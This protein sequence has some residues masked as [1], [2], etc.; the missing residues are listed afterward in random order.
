MSTHA[1]ADLDDASWQWAI[2]FAARGGPALAAYPDYARIVERFGRWYVASKAIARRHRM[3]IG[4]IASDAT[5]EVKW[6]RGGRLG[7]VEDCVGAVEFLVTPL[8][9]YVTGVVLPVD[10]LARPLGD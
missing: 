5:V 8:S 9:A 4:T 2:D 3:N 7:T 6:L 10:G 1:F